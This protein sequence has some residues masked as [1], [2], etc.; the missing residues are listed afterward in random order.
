MS[1]DDSFQKQRKRCK[2][3]E[4][5]RANFTSCCSYPTM[6]AWKWDVA[7]CT[8]K[9]EQ[10]GQKRERCCFNPCMFQTIGVL[11]NGSFKVNA[12]EL[13]NSFKISVGNDSI[14]EKPITDACNECVKK[15]LPIRVAAVDCDVIPIQLYNV[16]NCA[17]NEIY[18]NCP[19]WNP[20]NLDACNYTK[21]FINDCA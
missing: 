4:T 16:I 14:W 1:E 10:A 15:S 6:V 8:E 18:F 5:A 20:K 12:K 2:Y 13:A 17:Y 9:C 7:K 3:L 19:I 11:T 21:E